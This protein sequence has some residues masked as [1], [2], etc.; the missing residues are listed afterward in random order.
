ML[1]KISHFKY[2]PIADSLAARLRAIEDNYEKSKVYADDVIDQLWDWIINVSE[3]FWKEHFPNDI[4][5]CVG[6]DDFDSRL[7]MAIE[8]FAANGV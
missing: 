2:D 6:G 3:T 5:N 4:S 8:H 1:H 7:D